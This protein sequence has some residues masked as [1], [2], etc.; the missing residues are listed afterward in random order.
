MTNFM[1]S[2]ETMAKA[3]VLRS[4]ELIEI[5][6]KMELGWNLRVS[7]NGGSY[8]LMEM[9]HPMETVSVRKFRTLAAA[10]LIIPRVYDDYTEYNLT[11]DPSKQSIKDIV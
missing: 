8:Y 9:G 6:K 10:G 2:K 5:L 3:K 1:P 4:P 7:V 11:Y